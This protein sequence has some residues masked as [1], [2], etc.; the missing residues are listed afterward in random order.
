MS[1]VICRPTSAH[2]SSRG[3]SPTA[4]AAPWW[5]TSAPTTSRATSGSSSPYDAECSANL[6]EHAHGLIEVVA[7]VRRRDLASHARRALRHDR[8]SEA[9]DEHALVEQHVA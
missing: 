8:I 7:R 9:G 5:S 6:L 1:W 4:D 3:C 2:G